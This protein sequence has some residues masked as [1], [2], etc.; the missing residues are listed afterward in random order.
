MPDPVGSSF[1]AEN[2]R[3]MAHS[4]V[5]QWLIGQ[6]DDLLYTGGVPKKILFNGNRSLFK[7]LTGLND[8]SYDNPSTY[9]CCGEFVRTVWRELW[10]VGGK[11][12]PADYPAPNF[13]MLRS[14]QVTWDMKLKKEVDLGKN[15]GLYP[16]TYTLAKDPT[17]PEPGD[18]YVTSTPHIGIIR[19]F[20]RD[21]DTV[22]IE[23]Y[24]GGLTNQNDGIAFSAKHDIN[25]AKFSGWL[26]IDAALGSP[27]SAQGKP[28][29]FGIK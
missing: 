27:W 21:G 22:S 7:A 23:S 16:Y 8:S 15:N 26:D 10:K 24:D 19:Q 3:I 11:T 29:W 13:F 5:R 17:G 1:S 6:L 12:P 9:T 14:R 4:P 20:F 28:C 2:F 18:I 25:R